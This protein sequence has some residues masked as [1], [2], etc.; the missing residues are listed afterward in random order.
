VGG[1]D[2]DFFS[3]YEDVDLGFRLRLYGYR[4]L[5][6]PEATV[7]HVGSTTFGVKSDFVFYH[8]HRN[9]VW[10]FIKNMPA[11]L[12]WRSLPTHI[13]ANLVYVLYY[14]LTGRGRVL[15]R[16]KWDALRGLPSVLKK[17]KEIQKNRIVSDKEL[18]SAMERRWFQP[19]IRSFQYRR[20]VANS[21]KR[22][23]T[24]GS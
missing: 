21:K 24:G 20:A 1:F 8:T 22:R 9:L 2:E 23:T 12:F 7:K 19:Y 17:R 11:R 3:Y 16:A 6:V 4:C 13:V 10:T 18:L 15:W 14:T 5:Y